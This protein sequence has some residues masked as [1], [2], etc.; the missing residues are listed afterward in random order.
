VR[1]SR[2]GWPGGLRTNSARHRRP[3]EARR[4]HARRLR[5]ITVSMNGVR[6][7]LS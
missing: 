6:P 2:S 3:R 5:H 1:P 7:K 4:A